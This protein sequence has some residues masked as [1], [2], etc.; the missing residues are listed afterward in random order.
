MLSKCKSLLYCF[1]ASVIFIASN[2]E[3]VVSEQ[4]GTE[5][6]LGKAKAT[7]QL[8][9]K[10]ETF[11]T[12]SSNLLN[13]A[14]RSD[15]LFFNRGTV[16]L[17]GNINYA[18]L[19]EFFVTL[20]NQAT[21]G[22]AETIATT[23]ETEL[24]LLDAVFGGHRHYITRHVVWIREIWLKFL[25]NEALGLHF[26]N[27][28]FFTLGAFPFELGRGIALGSA[29]AVNPKFLGFYSDNTINQYAYGFKISGDVVPS[30]L[31]YDIYGAILENRNDSFTNS[32]L[33]ILGQQFGRRTTPERGPGKINFLVAGRLKWVPKK[34]DCALA[35]FEPYV[36]LDHIP[37]QIVEVPAD[38]SAKLATIGLAGEFV[39]GNF[40]WGFD[41]AFNLG[42]QK[43]AGLDRNKVEFENSNG[44]AVLVNSRVVSADPTTTPKPPKVLFDPNSVTGK[45]VQA[46][47]NTS[48]QDASQN[49]KQIGEVNGMPL[50]NALHRFRNPHT[51]IFKGWMFVADAAYWILKPTLKVAATVG[52][53]SGGENPNQ[54][55]DHPKDEVN[56]TFAGFIGLQE[57]YSGFRVQS[58]FF[59]GGA[60]RVPRPLSV[61]DPTEG[62][63]ELPSQISGFTNL[64]FTGLGLHWYPQNCKRV[65][66]VRP[67]VLFYWQEH[68]SK[69][70]DIF[71][72]MSSRHEFARNYL[73][74]EGNAFIDVAL[75]K[76]L[77]L[78]IVA[79]FF[80]PGSHFKDIKGTPLNKDQIK[81][82]DSLDVTGAEDIEKLPLLGNDVAYTLNIGLEYRY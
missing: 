55:F 17:N 41:S 3:D 68:A 8:K 40:E 46:I 75:L 63:D 23:T 12:N 6:S 26:D 61:P 16:D 7:L 30:K 34:T 31:Q 22:N 19:A 72:G 58:A 10:P 18:D 54:N 66:S 43:V 47:I 11:A 32:S 33:R 35:A 21:W 73:G 49:G 36:L 65:F 1:L 60:G 45:Q 56:R 14:V 50:F 44:F 62:I 57:L 37:E 15:R 5:F 71:N 79:S 48:P 9:F 74:C 29:Y 2:A 42:R 77:K 76:D 52:A 20:R 39:L 59:L 4:S 67:N 27:K 13:N 69:K 64:I 24:K 38:S 82:L 78:F 53:A 81:I 70:F 51:N 28:H 80:V 25:I